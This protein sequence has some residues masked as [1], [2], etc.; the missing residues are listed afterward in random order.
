M[1]FVAHIRLEFEGRPN[2]TAVYEYLHQLMEDGDLDFN[3]EE[4]LGLDPMDKL[5]Q[6]M[7]HEDLD[8]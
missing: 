1:S 8:D 5:T 4:T 3:V 6:R 2:K 7:Y